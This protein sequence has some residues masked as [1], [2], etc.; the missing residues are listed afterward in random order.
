MRSGAKRLRM[1]R[2]ESSADLARQRSSASTAAASPRHPLVTSTRRLRLDSRSAGGAA[3]SNLSAPAS[4]HSAPVVRSVGRADSVEPGPRRAARER[5]SGGGRYDRLAQQSTDTDSSHEVGPWPEDEPEVSAPSKAKETWGKAAEQ[6]KKTNRKKWATQLF[7]EK[8]KASVLR[9]V[10]S[11][12]D[13]DRQL[14][15]ELKGH[16]AR[17]K[18]CRVFSDDT[19]AISTSDDNTLRVW[20]LAT[21]KCIRTLGCDRSELLEH[22]P[23][24]DFPK[25]LGP[26]SAQETTLRPS[27]DFKKLQFRI[28]ESQIDSLRARSELSAQLWETL[29]KGDLSAAISKPHRI[30]L[31]KEAMTA[32]GIPET[33]THFVWAHQLKAAESLSNEEIAEFVN[34]SGEAAFVINGGYVY[35][36]IKG[37]MADRDV[38]DWEPSEYGAPILVQANALCVCGVVK[39]QFGA[40][41]EVGRREKYE[42]ALVKMINEHRFQ[43]VTI[44]PLRACGARYYCW[45]LPGEDLAADSGEPWVPCKHG[46]FMYLMTGAGQKSEDPKPED[47]EHCCYFELSLGHTSWVRSCCLLPDEKSVLSCSADMSLWLWD[48]ET[49]KS[50]RKLVGHTN[51]VW[52]CCTYTKTTGQLQAISCSSDRTV[53]VWDLQTFKEIEQL[54]MDEHEDWVMS[55]CVYSWRGNWRAVSTSKDKTM[56]S[57]DLETGE[58]LHTF[59]G[60]EDMVGGCEVYKRDGTNWEERARGVAGEADRALTCSDD[61]TLRVWNLDDEAG[62]VRCLHTLRG[63]SNII[64]A[65]CLFRNS[66]RDAH[67][68]QQYGVSCSADGRIGVWALEDG[69]C[70]R[71]LQDTDEN[72]RVRGCAA[73]SDGSKLLSCSGNVVRVWDRDLLLRT[74]KGVRDLSLTMEHRA[75]LLWKWWTHMKLHEH[76][77]WAQNLWNV[78]NPPGKEQLTPFDCQ[79]LLYGKDRDGVTLI[80]KLANED[81]GAAVVNYIL[82]QQKHGRRK[83][84]LGS[85]GNELMERQ[86]EMTLGLISRAGYSHGQSVLSVAMDGFRVSQKS[87]KRA[88]LAKAAPMVRLLLNDY[89]EMV[90]AVRW[91]QF[92]RQKFARYDRFEPLCEHDAV[93]LF[94][95]FPRDA[96]SFLQRLRLRPTR[97]LRPD[98]F[99]FITCDVHDPALSA[100]MMVKSAMDM[101]PAACSETNMRWWEKIIEFRFYKKTAKKKEGE[102]RGT[103]AGCLAQETTSTE[104][105]ATSKRTGCSKRETI[106]TETKTWLVPI[107]ASKTGSKTGSNLGNRRCAMLQNLCDRCITTG[108][109][110]HKLP[111]SAMLYQSCRY[112]ENYN[113]VELFEA[114]VLQAIICHKWEAG[115]RDIFM[116]HFVAFVIYLA[117]FTYLILFDHLTQLS[118]CDR[119]ATTCAA[120]ETC[121][122]ICCVFSALHLKFE[123]HQLHTLGTRKYFSKTWNQLGI[124]SVLITVL[125]LVLM[126]GQT[127]GSLTAVSPAALR[128]IHT[129]ALFSR[130]LKLLLFMRGLDSTAPLVKLLSNIVQEMK[131]F[132]V[133]LLVILACFSFV[134]CLL[135][136]DTDSDRDEFG[137]IYGAW[138]RTYGMILGNFHTQWF[139]DAETG[140][141]ATG[142]FVLFTVA[143]PVIMLNA[144]IAIMSDTYGR[145]KTQEV[146]NGRLMRANLILELES[147]IVIAGTRDTD[148]YGEQRGVAS[149]TW[150]SIMRVLQVLLTFRIRGDLQAAGTYLH[151]LSFEDPDSGPE[152]EYELTSYPF[153]SDTREGAPVVAIGD[154]SQRES[155]TASKADVEKLMAQN[156][157]LMGEMRAQ[158]EQFMRELRALQSEQLAR[159]TYESR[160]ARLAHTPE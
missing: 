21:G 44:A 147:L 151:V 65:C 143:V 43:K 85:E 14:I 29:G 12:L 97:D 108:R 118:D 93:S 35:F 103:P 62:P 124:A 72:S 26:F 130:W 36:Q 77:A 19:K 123:L 31:P 119:E 87:G 60:H 50:L 145:S 28:P 42:R 10:S 73:L 139:D 76:K 155:L 135:L 91:D 84:V 90:N 80:H 25:E 6:V 68:R 160:A 126:Q 47:C 46:G 157:Q 15:T 113:S 40:C 133:L 17:T 102:E 114:P 9:R 5:A 105:K 107:V 106:K 153:E 104:A 45:V 56:K 51:W 27:F 34:I 81:D 54:R 134:F 8:C 41:V 101:W 74:E 79:T 111:F 11:A 63:H 18:A 89:C 49:G 156:V 71:F 37:D 152:Q 39:F 115:C 82:S 55:C 1:R 158:R 16:T 33:A 3:T 30:T 140:G 110:V 148:G 144:L 4:I 125:A 20:D 128:T 22:R 136:R 59:K 48:L 122:K 92:T 154:A 69:T 96:V 100:R 99:D 117:I 95:N 137:T 57:W 109:D 86:A 127:A 88:S 67:K 53:R 78:M 70:E 13:N 66:G 149:R 23:P 112:A 131:S 94:K 75:E 98:G 2:L 7:S 146:A 64:I 32:A 38:S 58:C 142:L 132:M 120:A 129:A 52:D 150:G 24:A 61:R 83:A 141:L 138:L 159:E 121:W 116:I